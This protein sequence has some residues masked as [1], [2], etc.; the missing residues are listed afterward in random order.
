MNTNQMSSSEETFE[1]ETCLIR[2][3][4]EANPKSLM[5]WLWRWHTGWCPGW[6]KYQEHLAK[7]T[8]KEKGT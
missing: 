2:K 4:S 8:N 6:K 5:A 7:Q 3:K 1:C